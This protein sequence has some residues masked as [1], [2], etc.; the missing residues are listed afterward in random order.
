LTKDEDD[1]LRCQIG[2]SNGRGGGRRYLPYAF[3]YSR[4]DRDDNNIE[5][6]DTIPVEEF[7]RRFC[8]HAVPKGFR[9][10]RYCGWLSAARRKTALPAI[11]K[12]LNRFEE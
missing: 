3:T 4:R 5:K 9:K 10:I 12:A 1:A 6:P 8:Y 2:T 7:T 11:R